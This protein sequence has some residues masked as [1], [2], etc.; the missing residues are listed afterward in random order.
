MSTDAKTAMRVSLEGLSIGDAFGQRFFTHPEIVDGLIAERAVPS[1]PWSYT[2]DT[3]MALSIVSVLEDFG[4]ID[5]D[6]LASRF[7]CNYN[8]TRE[9][10]AAMHQALARVRTGESWESVSRSLFGGEGSFGNGAAMRVAPLG[11]FFADDFDAVVAEAAKSAEVT[12]AHPEAIAGAIAVAI[13]AAWST[14]LRGSAL[15]A[16]AAELID[17]VIPHVPE[18]LVRSGLLNARELD[19]SESSSTAARLLGNG[20]NVTAHDTVP[21]VVW[22]AAKHLGDFVEG[23]WQTVSGLGDRDTTCAMVGG[24]VAA[25]V[26]EEGLPVNWIERRE[27]LAENL[28]R[29]PE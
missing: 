29:M 24:I 6:A 27:P 3:E 8:S 15:L 17:L 10:G 16:N 13:T 25:F 14:R 21:F 5:Q 11:V 26:G 28:T 4:K 18:G 22:S 19:E 23:M 9:Y 1:G 2:D 20:E 7:A 12:H